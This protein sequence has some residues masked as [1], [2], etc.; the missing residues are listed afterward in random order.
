MEEG[1]KAEEKLRMATQ[2]MATRGNVI[3]VTNIFNLPTVV[4]GII[5]GYVGYISLAR[6]AHAS[7]QFNQW[8]ATFFDRMRNEKEPTIAKKTAKELFDL[9]KLLFDKLEVQFSNDL[10]DN[11]PNIPS[12]N[13]EA[14][15]DCYRLLQR[16]NHAV[17]TANMAHD[18][19]SLHPLIIMQAKTL[20]RVKKLNTK[21]MF[22]NKSEIVEPYIEEKEVELYLTALDYEIQLLDKKPL[23]SETR[24]GQ[25]LN[26]LSQQ[27]EEVYANVQLPEHKLLIA[28]KALRQ[29]E[30]FKKNAAFGS[31]S[32]NARMQ[33]SYCMSMD[34]CAEVWRQRA[35]SLS[36]DLNVNNVP[37]SR[38]SSCCRIS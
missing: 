8:K 14:Y 17:M 18:D 12:R 30:A 28:E 22:C 24:L 29:V 33:R 31:N 4:L 25:H 36:K 20:L 3:P 21:E 34:R 37:E 23:I 13:Q 27:Y 15:S 16:I 11:A 2:Q 10:R 32:K 6:A 7:K 26:F 9:A 35:K 5:E 38:K 19:A 1:K